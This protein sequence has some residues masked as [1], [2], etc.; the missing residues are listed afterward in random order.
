LQLR[1]FHR[2]LL[3]DGDVELRVVPEGEEKIW[4]GSAL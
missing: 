4:P 3:Q 1:V 2:G